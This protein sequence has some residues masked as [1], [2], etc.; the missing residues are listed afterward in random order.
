MSPARPEAV[1]RLTGSKPWCPTGRIALGLKKQ[2]DA[3]VTGDK[4]GPR[5]DKQRVSATSQIW[6]TPP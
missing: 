2:M 1:G 5:E 4:H 3:A 6:L